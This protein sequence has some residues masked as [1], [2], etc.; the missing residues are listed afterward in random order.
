MS[1]HHNTT[2]NF[3]HSP[4]NNSPSSI[5]IDLKIKSG[6]LRLRYVK[7]LRDIYTYLNEEE[8]KELINEADAIWE[9]L[10]QQKFNSKT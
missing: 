10:S 4:Y 3:S 2:I 9:K 7:L 1:S 8:A 6:E 5:D